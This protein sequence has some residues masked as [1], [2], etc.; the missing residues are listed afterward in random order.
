MKL[1]S[2]VIFCALLGIIGASLGCSCLRFKEGFD[3]ITQWKAKGELPWDGP[4]SVPTATVPNGW[5]FANNKSSPE[6]CKAATYSTSTGCLCTTKEQLN[7]LNQ[8]G[9][10]RTIEDGF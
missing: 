3:M 1:Q 6:C 2:I 9:G 7:F 4:F 5:F 8:R 10:N